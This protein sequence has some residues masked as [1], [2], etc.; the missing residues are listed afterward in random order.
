MVPTVSRSVLKITHNTLPK[1]CLGQWLSEVQV[2][3]FRIKPAFDNSIIMIEVAPLFLIVDASTRIERFRFQTSTTFS[4]PG[5]HSRTYIDGLILHIV[6]LNIDEYNEALQQTGSMLVI[7]RKF[8]RMTIEEIKPKIDDAFKVNYWKSAGVKPYWKKESIKSESENA[9]IIDNLPPIPYFKQFKE[10]NTEEQNALTQCMHTETPKEEDLQ[11]IREA[12]EFNR[13]CFT[14]LK[15]IDLVSLTDAH[16][17]KLREYLSYVY[18]AWPCIFN[19]VS[20]QFLYRATVVSDKFLLDGKV[21]NAKYLSYPPAELIKE[22]G[23][24]NRASTPERTLFYAAERENVAV[25]EIKPKV[26]SRIIVSTWLNHSGKPLNCF[27]ICLS[28]GIN[29]E[30]ADHASYAFEVIAEKMNPVVAE[31]MASMF[32]FIA[33]EYIKEAEPINPKR[34]DYLFSALFADG[35]LQQFPDGSKLNDYDAIVYPSVA[36]NHIP[37]NVAIRPEVVD[38]R[39]SLIEAKEYEVGETWYNKEISLTQYPADLKLIR[40]AT[41]F[42][43]DNISWND[44]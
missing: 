5:T 4:F 21:R 29:N 11:I 6:N 37:N 23:L 38:L 7:H 27:P 8:E 12:I 9:A 17:E 30:M 24:Y 25:R 15:E 36:W 41:S 31:W 34:Y 35:M 10:Q 18:N 39:F 43:S 13:S 20:V 16:Y 3:N 33:S 28:A 22:R 44:D 40:Q 32:E 14:M 2:M 42:T 19:D 26:G 1:H